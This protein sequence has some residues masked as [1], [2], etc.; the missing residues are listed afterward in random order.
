MLGSPWHLPVLGFTTVGISP[1]R[2]LMSHPKVKW[3]EGWIKPEAFSVTETSHQGSYWPVPQGRAGSAHSL[4]PS[5]PA[6]PLL[7]EHRAFWFLSSSAP[8]S[9]EA[10]TMC[11]NITFITTI[12]YPGTHRLASICQLKCKPLYPLSWYLLVFPQ[13][14][15]AHNPLAV[16]PDSLL[17]ASLCQTNGAS[18]LPH[19]TFSLYPCPQLPNLC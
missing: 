13:W 4:G 10:K 6:H 8:T 2:L 16:I 1:G 18:V 11:W 15:P 5:L 12:S 17:R 3:E 7:N 19:P 9:R 14:T